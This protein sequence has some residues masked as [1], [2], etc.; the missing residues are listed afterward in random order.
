MLSLDQ[1]LAPGGMECYDWSGLGLHLLKRRGWDRVT[2][3]SLDWN[4]RVWVVYR[5]SLLEGG[6]GVM[7]LRTEGEVDAKTASAVHVP[8]PVNVLIPFYK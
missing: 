5:L 2:D 8:I 4:T 3:G 7:A 6:A 1:S